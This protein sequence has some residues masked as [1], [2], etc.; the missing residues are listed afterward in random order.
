MEKKDLALG[1]DTLN[2]LREREVALTGRRYCATCQSPQSPLGGEKRGTA[3]RCALC[4]A[5]AKTRTRTP[6]GHAR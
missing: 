4:V 1:H 5:R 6:G 3:W 2:H